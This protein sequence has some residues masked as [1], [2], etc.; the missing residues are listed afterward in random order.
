MLIVNCFIKKKQTSYTK[1]QK[2][3]K[4]WSNDIQVDDKEICLSVQQNKMQVGKQYEIM[5]NLFLPSSWKKDIKNTQRSLINHFVECLN[6]DNSEIFLFTSIINSG[7]I[8]ESG[9]IKEW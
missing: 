8:I 1:L 7:N 3:I 9:E 2:V 5:V 6:V 4:H